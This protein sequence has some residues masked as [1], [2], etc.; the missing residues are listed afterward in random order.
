MFLVALGLFG[1]LFGIGSSEVRRFENSAA[2]DIRSRLAGEKRWVQV[3]TKLD[4]FEAIGGKVRSATISAGD[5]STDGLP[6]F[7]QP[8]LSTRGKLG[9]LKIALRNFELTGLQVDSLD[10][11]IPDCRYD[12]GLAQRRGQMRLSRSGTGVGTVVVSQDKLAAFVLKRFPGI[13]ALNLTL[14]NGFATV[15][16]DGRFVAF[17]THVKIIGKLAAPDGNAI[18]LSDARVWI[19]DKE[20]APAMADA[21]LKFLN[22]VLDLDRDLKL[23]GAL[24]VK[25]IVL[26]KGKLQA[27][28]VAIIPNQPIGTW[29]RNFGLYF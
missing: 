7:T 21:V 17:Q 20:A 26:E 19:G 27:S 8:E 6:F 22:P 28:G 2:N 9:E 4:P 1:L 3:R 11:R 5:F 16:G 14:E 18:L 15:E 23:F 12:F 24:R 13:N 25:E 29:M 10:A